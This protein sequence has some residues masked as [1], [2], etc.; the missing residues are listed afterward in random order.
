MIVLQYA[1]DLCHGSSKDGFCGRWIAL[2]GGK[3]L[4]ATTRNVS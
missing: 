3:I 2:K 4:P 1:H